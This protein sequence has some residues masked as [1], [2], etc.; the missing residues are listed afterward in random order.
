MK[1]GCTQEEKST[2]LQ[3]S[4]AQWLALLWVRG[5]VTYRAG[6]GGGDGGRQ[7]TTD[8]S[9][10]TAA[11]SRKDSVPSWLCLQMRQGQRE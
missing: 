4:L 9:G 6:Q 11:S 8:S 2:G 1:Q 3:F 10:Q 7:I 5:R